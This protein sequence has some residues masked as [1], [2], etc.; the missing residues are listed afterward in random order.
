MRPSLADQFPECLVT[1]NGHPHRWAQVL[2]LAP[3]FSPVAF[4]H[5]AYNRTFRT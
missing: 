4:F 5:S 3:Y 1:Q 2:L